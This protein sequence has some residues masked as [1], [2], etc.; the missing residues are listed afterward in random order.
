MIFSNLKKLVIPEGEVEKIAIGNTVVWEKIELLPHTNLVPTA[1]SQDG[2]IFNSVG[3]RRGGFWNMTSFSTANTAFTAIGFI[4][5]GTSTV[6][7]DIYVYGLNFSGSSYNRFYLYGSDFTVKDYSISIKDGFSNTITPSITKLGDGYFRITTKAY[8][9]AVKY[10]TISGV[11]ID[12]VEPIV[13][14]DQ[15]LL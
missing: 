14:I 5:F 15:P 12:G 4:P 3:Y 7:H 10:F 2:S 9:T 11:T 8:S 6:K 1:I 13:T